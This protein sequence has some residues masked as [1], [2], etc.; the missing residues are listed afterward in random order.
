MTHRSRLLHIATLLLALAT[1]A[2][3]TS[4]PTSGKST[5]GGPLTLADQ[6][7]FFVGGRKINSDYTA[8]PMAAL[9]KPGQITVDQ[10]YV[11]YMIPAAV[12]GVPVVMMHGFNHTGVTFETTPDGREG[13]ATYFVRKGHPV[14]VVDQ[15]GRG[16]SGFDPTPFNRAKVAG[17]VNGQPSVPMYPMASAWVN[18]RFGK[19]YPTAFPG[20]QFPLDSP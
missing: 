17:D 13:W 16:R 4:P 10:M 7:S 11:Q 3:V 20:L 12:R 5:L 2:C 9:L 15:P 14:Y 18:F 19:E 1:S 8:A 6:G